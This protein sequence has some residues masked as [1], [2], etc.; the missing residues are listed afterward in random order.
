MRIDE[1]NTKITTLDRDVKVRVM[2]PD[3]YEKGDMKYPCLYID[4][5]QDVFRDDQTFW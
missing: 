1:I 2:T 4:D 5:G 3:G